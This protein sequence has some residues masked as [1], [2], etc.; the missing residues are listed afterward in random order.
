M[1][2]KDDTR[3]LCGKQGLGAG[4]DDART[5]AK[6]V[7]AGV[8]ETAVQALGFGFRELQGSCKKS[9]PSN[10]ILAP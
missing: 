1:T 6:V 3:A 7:A 5:V 2:Y 4:S 10:V 8:G 9:V